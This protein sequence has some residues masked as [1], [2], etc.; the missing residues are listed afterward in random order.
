M[1]DADG[2]RSAELTSRWAGPTFY[3][4]FSFR[5]WERASGKLPNETMAT[6]LPPALPNFYAAHTNERERLVLVVPGVAARTS[7]VHPPVV[8]SR[9]SPLPRFD[10]AE[11][12]NFRS[13]TSAG[14]GCS[15]EHL[16]E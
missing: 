2:M 7:Y 8:L 5:W 16:F 9:L 6:E 12:E 10:R 11:T 13:D 4:Y 15:R 3:F 1:R 14:S